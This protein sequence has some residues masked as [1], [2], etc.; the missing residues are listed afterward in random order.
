[1]HFSD[2]SKEFLIQYDNINKA[3]IPLGS[4]SYQSAVNYVNGYLIVSIIVLALQL[5]ASVI[6]LTF[7]KGLLSLRN[8]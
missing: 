1:M 7:A 2:E 3:K 6:G 4:S 5:L 8:N